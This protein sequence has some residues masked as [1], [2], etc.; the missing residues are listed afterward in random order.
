MADEARDN[1]TGPQKSFMTVGPTLHYSHANVH[2]CWVVSVLIYATTCLFWTWIQTGRIMPDWT[3]LF[4]FKINRLHPYVTNPLSIYEYPW[5]I[6]VLASLMGIMAV[7]PVI[8]SQLLSFKYSLPFIL[9][10][11]FLARLP[12]F[13][14]VLAVGCVG[15]ACRPLRFRSRFIAIALCMAPQLAYWAILGGGESDPIQWGFSYAPWMGAWLIG[16]TIAGVVIGIGHFTRYRPGL[17]WT[18]TGIALAGTVAT[19][20]TKIS[21]AELDYQL[22]I[23]GNNPEEVREFHDHDMRPILNHAME[24]AGTKAFLQQLFYPTEPILLREELK[25]EIQIQLGYDRWPNWFDVPPELRYQEKRQYLLDQYAYFIDKWP[26]SKRLAN[27][28]YFQALLNEYSPDIR[29]FGQRETLRFY[30]DYPHHE[31]LPIWHRIVDQA[32]QSPESTEARYRMAVHQAG[33]GRFSEAL[34]FCD[35]NEKE[36]QRHLAERTAN[37]S[38]Q[39]RFWKVFAE[40]PATVITTGKL[41]RLL[42]KVRQLTSLIQQQQQMTAEDSKRRLSQFLILNPYRPDYADRLEELL[43]ATAQADPLRDNLLLAQYSLITDSQLRS[44]KLRE[45]IE[46]FPRSD[47]AVQALYELGLLEVNR[48]K[49]PEAAPEVKQRHLSQARELLAQFLEKYPDSMY[50]SPAREILGGLPNP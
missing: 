36:I 12:L 47:A 14:V 43:K 16:L 34:V 38:S 27:A 41:K 31:N 33:R 22:Y 3:G 37:G 2:W 49:D 24:D 4:E 50:A 32:P 7:A 8:V 29:L 13:A 10:A 11:A 25:K 23:A 19:F 9:C 39:E 5:Q 26:N 48:W 28:L 1:T 30:S 15:A 45:L 18:I 46:Q 42:L 17:V 20:M 6:L 21:F 44:D 40:P 35:V